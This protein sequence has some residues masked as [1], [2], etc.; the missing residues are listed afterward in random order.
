[1]FLINLR[2][3]LWVKLA[4]VLTLAGLATV[5][6]RAQ[7][8]QAG[9]PARGGLFAPHA[10][11]RTDGYDPPDFDRFFPD[12][13]EGGGRLEALWKAADRDRRSD[14]EILRT[15]RAGLRRVPIPRNPIVAWVG[16]RFVWGRPAQ[17]PDAIEIMYHAADFRGEGGDRYGTRSNAVYYGLS[18]V[19]PKPPALLHALADLCALAGNG[20]DWSRIAWG[21]RS[22]RAELV[23]YLKPHMDSDDEAARER[24]VVVAKVLGGDPDALAFQIRWNR[25]R[26]L[27]QYGD[28]LPGIKKALQEGSSR[29]RSN[30][31]ALL[32]NDGWS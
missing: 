7:Q 10:W 18:V 31:L 1:M 30:A 4:L 15:V 8:P 2:R 11:S 12:D 22:Q 24:M 26:A 20:H 3:A 23:A 6:A 17:D 13:P 32:A 21:A 5:A 27:A 28:R 14:E 9:A 16:K 19:Q 29:E 25:K